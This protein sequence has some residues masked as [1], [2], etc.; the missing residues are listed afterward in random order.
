MRALPR[1]RRGPRVALRAKGRLVSTATCRGEGTPA[2]PVS[3]VLGRDVVGSPPRSKGI[4]C[5]KPALVRRL[6]PLAL[7][8]VP[9]LLSASA[10]DGT[11]ATTALPTIAHNVRFGTTMGKDP[12]LTLRL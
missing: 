4:T 10:S 11:A 12:A 5:M 6:A 7:L 3:D 1:D 9:V 2:I 8:A